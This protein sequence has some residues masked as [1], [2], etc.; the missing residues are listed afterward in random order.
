MKTYA[1]YVFIPLLGLLFLT[2]VSYAESNPDIDPKAQP[3]TQAE[4]DQL[5]APVALYPDSLL[6][7]ILMASSYPLEVVEAARWSRANPGFEGEAAVRMVQ[8][9]DWDASVKS[10]VAFPKV[11]EMMDKDLDWT[12]NLGNAYVSLPEQ[13]MDTVQGL[14]R[15]ADANGNLKS[16]DRYRVQDD[17]GNITIEPQNPEIVYVPYYDTRVVYGPWWWPGYPPVYWAP[18]PGYYAY[19]GFYGFYWSAGIFVG[20]RF[21]FGACNWPLRHVT[22]VKQ[23][24]FAQQIS[25]KSF[26]PH[27]IWSHD[28]VHRRGVHF[29]RPFNSTTVAN[30]FQSRQPKFHGKFPMHQQSTRGSQ[31]EPRQNSH[32]Q[33]RSEQGK[34]SVDSSR[35]F[36]SRS[37]DRRM[38]SSRNGV[39]STEMESSGGRRG[40]QRGWSGRGGEAQ[41]MRTRGS[42]NRGSFSSRGRAQGFRGAPP[43]NFSR[44]GSFESKAVQHGRFS[45]RAQ[46]PSVKGAQ[47]SFSSRRSVSS[48]FAGRGSSHTRG[49][50]STGSWSKGFSGKSQSSFGGRSMNWQSSGGGRGFGGFSRGG[51]SGFRG[52]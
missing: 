27:R 41:G 46:T 25:H 39:R 12:Q 34:R 1:K 44:S 14:R 9:R 16:D 38:P 22:V 23:P 10:L 20:S 43:S 50:F 52:R 37:G 4:L 19:P 30:S 15:K 2:P 3:Y 5:L 28:P 17:E 48:G 47:T 18:W 40:F 29:R 26:G 6:S 13:V 49:N 24:F 32:F 33:S 45:S 35:R 31:F 7:Q 42:A 11:L 36:E 51:G 8:G 21:F